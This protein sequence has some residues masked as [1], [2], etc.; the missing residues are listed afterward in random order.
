[1]YLE[2]KFNYKLSSKKSIYDNGINEENK[3]SSQ[4]FP[5]A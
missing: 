2:T 3:S 4:S 5:I 1:M